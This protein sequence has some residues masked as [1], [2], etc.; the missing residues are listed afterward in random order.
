MQTMKLNLR[1]FLNIFLLFIL[2]FFCVSCDSNSKNNVTVPQFETD[3]AYGHV[4]E[5]LIQMGWEPVVSPES[6][7]CWEGDVRCTNRPE[8]EACSGTGIAPCVFV[9]RKENYTLRVYTV[10]EDAEV[11]GGD[12]QFSSLEM[13]ETK[14]ADSK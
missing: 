2:S 5:K 6:D 8:M 9:W 13:I 4:R 3:E 7:T 14:R 12:A 10:G 11:E 1:F